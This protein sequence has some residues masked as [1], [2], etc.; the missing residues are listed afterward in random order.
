[1]RIHKQIKF[2]V[3]TEK[4]NFETREEVFLDISSR[5]TKW[6]WGWRLIQVHNASEHYT[7]RHWEH[8]PW[9]TLWNKISVMENVLRHKKPDKKSMTVSKS[10]TILILLGLNEYVDLGL[11]KLTLMTKS[12]KKKKSWFSKG[13]EMYK[14]LTSQKLILQ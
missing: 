12:S 11:V 13:E 1:M 9:N 2:F 5:T 6:L 8:L 3:S 10:D 7:Q 4:E 14:I